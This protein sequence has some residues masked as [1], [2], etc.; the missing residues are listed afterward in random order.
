M[1][2][3][4]KSVEELF[5]DQENCRSHDEK[6]LKAITKSLEA[7]GQQKPIVIDKSGKVIAGNGTLSAAQSLGWKT[8]DVVVSHLEGSEATAFGIA[9][10]RTAELAAWNDQKLV[11]SL[12]MLQN[13]M[14]IDESISGFS[15]A[16]IESRIEALES[17]EVKEIDPEDFNGQH[18]CPKC[19]FEFDD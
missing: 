16:E 6:N 1:Q 3:E 11:E 12:A 5:Q 2:V 7:F 13:D 15:T 18:E 9:D 10:N 14:S 8:I 19:G 4:K 17:P